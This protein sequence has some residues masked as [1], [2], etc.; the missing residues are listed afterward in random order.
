MKLLFL[1][2]SVGIILW[3]F[4]WKAPLTFYCGIKYGVSNVTHVVLCYL[5]CGGQGVNTD[6]Q[7]SLLKEI[8]I[9][10][11]IVL[12]WMGCISHTYPLLLET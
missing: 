5:S 10:T 6:I 3:H 1:I 2:I 4:T 8:F 9:A 11:N 12:V 7:K